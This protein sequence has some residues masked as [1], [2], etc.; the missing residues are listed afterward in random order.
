MNVIDIAMQEFLN[1]RNG[2]RDFDVA[3][4]APLRP[5]DTEKENKKEGFVRS[6]TLCTLAAS[7]PVR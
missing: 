1:G 3:T 2:L 6:S 4:D 7:F 5:C